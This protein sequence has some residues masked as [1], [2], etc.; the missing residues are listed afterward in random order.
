MVMS[1]SALSFISTFPYPG[2]YPDPYACSGPG[3]TTG[4]PGRAGSLHAPLVH[5]RVHVA[6]PG[7]FPVGYLDV[8]PGRRRGLLPG[9]PA[10]GPAEPERAPD[11]GQPDGQQEP[12]LAVRDDDH[13]F[14]LLSLTACMAATMA[15]LWSALPA[16]APL[17]HACHT[18]S[19]RAGGT[20]YQSV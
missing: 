14:P 2:P 12:Q 4:R 6:A 7:L 8:G 18:S 11:D 20:R 3:T 10:A 17:R 19:R 16:P 5:P 9:V 15:A 1:Y 13:G